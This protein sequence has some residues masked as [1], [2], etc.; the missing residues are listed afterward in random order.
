MN[1]HQ[2]LKKI[3]I[4]WRYIKIRGVYLKALRFQI[5]L[6]TYNQLLFNSIKIFNISLY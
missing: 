5:N 2:C 4:H 3:R 6:Y 1:T